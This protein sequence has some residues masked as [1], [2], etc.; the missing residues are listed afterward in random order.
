MPAPV[1][2]RD[3]V[4]IASVT[5]DGKD[6]S[7]TFKMSILEYA[8]R[9]IAADTS[10]EELTLMKDILAYIKAAYIYFDTEDRASVAT[11]IDEILGGYSNT[12]AKVEDVS[13][14]QAGLWGVIIVINDKPAVRFVLPEGVTAEGYT[15][16]SYG[17]VL[18]FT[19]GTTVIDGVSYNYAE[20][21]LYAYQMI[22]EISYSCAAANG[23]WHINSYYDFI[24]T[25]AELKDDVNLIALV[26]KLYNYCK[27]AEAYRLSVIN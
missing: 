7:A 19:T 15:F 20:V 3:I 24:T 22:N 4:L 13:D 16:K 26:E 9:V 1:A 2:A 14:A 11:K 5:I 8:R 25:D 18:D 12:F 17:R 23:S 27:S 21:S 10:A 6:Y